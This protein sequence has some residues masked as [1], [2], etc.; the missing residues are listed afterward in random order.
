M[1]LTP[2]LQDL[3]PFQPILANLIL[4]SGTLQLQL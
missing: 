4:E 1:K 3:F 2:D